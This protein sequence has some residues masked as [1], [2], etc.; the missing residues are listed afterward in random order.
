[1]RGGAV[2]RDISERQDAQGRERD[3]TRHATAPS[4]Q[5]E[6]RPGPRTDA[7]PGVSVKREYTDTRLITSKF[8]TS[9]LSQSRELRPDRA[10]SPRA[11]STVCTR[12]GEELSAVVRRRLRGSQTKPSSSAY[13]KKSCSPSVAAASKAANSGLPTPAPEPT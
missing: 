1:M 11:S 10:A 8:E 7:A 2:Y 6:R 5:P 3:V 9:R 12:P 13:R 4:G